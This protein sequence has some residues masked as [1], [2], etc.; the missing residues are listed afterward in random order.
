MA[1][2]LLPDE[3]WERINELL[4]P[5]KPRRFRFPGRKP[6]DNRKALTGILFVLKTGIPWEYLPLEMGC[7]S[8]MTCWRRLRDWQAPRDQTAA[9]RD[10]PAQAEAPASTRSTGRARSSTLRSCG[11]WAVGKAS[12]PR[13]WGR[14]E[15][16]KQASPSLTPMNKACTLATATTATYGDGGAR[17]PGAGRGRDAAGT[18]Q[19]GSAP[20]PPPVRPYGDRG[21][22]SEPERRWLRQRRIEPFLAPSGTQHGSG[23]GVYRWVVERTLSWL[24]AKRKLRVRTDRRTDIHQ[25]FSVLACSLICLIF[26]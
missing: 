2:P 8:G 9:P 20:P 26:L 10:P 4:P 3:L 13:P 7:G 23:L 1:K 22:D 18:R 24:H 5:P 16:R 25:A 11:P 15:I 12:R 21:Y 17:P 14:A 6:L 19:A